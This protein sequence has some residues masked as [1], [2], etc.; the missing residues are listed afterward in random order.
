M[1]P[2]IDP[3]PGPSVTDVDI[4]DVE[5]DALLLPIDGARSGLEGNIA[6]QFARR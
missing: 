4:L 5:A 2:L 6:R 3:Q 1:S